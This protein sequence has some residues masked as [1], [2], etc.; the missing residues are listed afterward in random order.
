MMGFK[1]SVKASAQPLHPCSLPVADPEGV[2]EVRLN[3]HPQFL[4]IP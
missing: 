1:A 2:Q 4:N 3:P